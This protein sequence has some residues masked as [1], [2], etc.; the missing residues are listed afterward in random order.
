M[1]GLH[2]LAPDQRATKTAGIGHPA[3]RDVD[4]DMPFRDEVE[5]DCGAVGEERHDGLGAVDG[6]AGDALEDR[7]GEVADPAAQDGMRGLRAIVPSEVGG[8]HGCEE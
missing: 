7:A 2:E 3:G 8:A 4:G 6:R 1:D 5:V